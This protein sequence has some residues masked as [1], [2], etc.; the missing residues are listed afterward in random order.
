MIK[1]RVVESGP[2]VCPNRWT[3]PVSPSSRTACMKG[4]VDNRTVLEP[5]ASALET[6]WVCACEVTVFNVMHFV[7]FVM[8]PPPNPRFL[9]GT[10][11]VYFVLA[12]SSYAI[13]NCMVGYLNR[14]FGKAACIHWHWVA[15]NTHADMQSTFFMNYVSN[16]VV[17][18]DEILPNVITCDAANIS[19]FF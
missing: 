2:P 19:W 17:I 8:K 13:C 12:L 16:C 14:N 18:A 10:S 1:S 6:F 11:I 4:F 9:F 15:L 3:F 7:W 5:M